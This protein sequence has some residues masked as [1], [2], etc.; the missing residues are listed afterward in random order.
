MRRSKT[1]NMMIIAMYAAILS[2]LAQVTIPLP[3]IPITGQTLAVGLIATIIGSR[4]STYTVLIYLALGT[5][6]IPVFS[7]FTSGLGVLFGPT[8][9][10]LFGFIPAAFLTGYW[11]EKRGFTITQAIIANLIGMIVTLIFGALWLKTAASLSWN[12]ALLTGITPFVP[13]G[14]LK[15]MM[16][17]YLGIL[18]RKRLFST[19]L[20]PAAQ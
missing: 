5:I 12:A 3:L 6:G 14:I 19:R 8:G 2:I 1:K 20:L 10:Y 13:V 4:F 7:G 17:A 9:G 16:A 11:L 18:I 15:A